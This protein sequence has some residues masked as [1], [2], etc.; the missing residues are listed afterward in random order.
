MIEQHASV[1]G[2]FRDVLTQAMRN[3]RVSASELTEMYLVN[4]LAEFAHSTDLRLKRSLTVML[5]E[6]IESSGSDR[7]QRLREVG[8]TALYV[9]GFFADHLDRRGVDR[10]YVMAVGGR[11]Y[12]SAAQL[13][14]HPAVA[15]ADVYESVY[16]ELARKFAELVEVLEEVGDASLR[17]DRDVLRLYDRWLRTR[18]ERLARALAR[19]GLFP[20]GPDG[21]GDLH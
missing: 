7:F 15:A 2:Y 3:Q 21:R 12:G 13:V 9:A 5:A 10:R 19:E 4:L 16:L 1:S 8:D 17:T 11:A 20:Q 18:S 6:A 14:R